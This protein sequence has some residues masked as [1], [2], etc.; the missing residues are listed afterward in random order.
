MLKNTA[1]GILSKMYLLQNIQHEDKPMTTI[2]DFEQAH[3]KWG[4]VK[5][6]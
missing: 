1:Y 3:E 6:V 5:L 4:G 2:S